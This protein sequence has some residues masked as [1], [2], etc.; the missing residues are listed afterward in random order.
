MRRA[1]AAIAV[2]ITIAVGMASRKI[3]IGFFLWDKSLGDALYTV[4]IYF[5]IAIAKPALHPR[6][7]GAIAL[8][9]SIA[10]EMFQLTGIPLRLPRVLQLALG[11]SFELHDIACYIVGAG[12]VATGHYLLLGSSGGAGRSGGGQEANEDSH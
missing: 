12:A 5:F 9:I 1:H 4:M 6:V 7:L 3:P 11:T 8:G 2:A 10:V